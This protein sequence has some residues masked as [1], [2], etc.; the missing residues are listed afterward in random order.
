[1]DEILVGTS[2]YSYEDWRG[3]FYPEGLPKEEFLRYYSLFFPF[4]ELNFSYYTMPSRKA[5]TAMADR[6]HAGFGFT[7]KAH[8]S[9]THEPGPGWRDDATAFVGAAAALAERDRLLA[10]LVQLPYSFHHTPERRTF[11]AN[12]LDALTP[13]PLAVE[14]R[15]DEWQ[16]Q[17]VEDGLRERGVGV[18]MVDRPELPGLPPQ[19]EAVTGPVAYVR[20]HGRNES[21]WWD[22][23]ATSRYDYLYSQEELDAALPR[24]RRMA[25][26]ARLLV[27][28][29]NHARGNAPRNAGELKAKIARP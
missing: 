5:L 17:R 7:L 4:V 8:K 28:F 2:G 21:A 12:L 14:F 18:V 9:L 16:G 26:K 22:G 23:D 29:N 6:T 11:L 10:A 3:S 24:L 1:M 25:S 13:L 19:G 27:A 15:N 20:F